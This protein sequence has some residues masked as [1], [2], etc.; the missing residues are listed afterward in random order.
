LQRGDGLHG[1]GTADDFNT[2]FREPEV[3]DLTGVD[4]VFDGSG[5]VLDRHVGVDPVLVEQIDPVG[6]QSL[7]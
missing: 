7:Q 3:A 5:D 1:M 2:G 4:E 6:P